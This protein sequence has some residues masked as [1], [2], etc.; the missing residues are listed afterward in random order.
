MPN[1]GISSTPAENAD[2]AELASIALFSCSGLLISL[3]VVVVRVYGLFNSRLRRASRSEQRHHPAA[4]AL[5]PARQ[6][7]LEQHRAHDGG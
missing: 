3:V 4:V 5:E 1:T 6:L 2:A 7:E